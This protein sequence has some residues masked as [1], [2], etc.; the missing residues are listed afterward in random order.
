MEITKVRGLKRQ[1][2]GETDQRTKGSEAQVSHPRNE[3]GAK[4]QM[5]QVVTEGG[6]KHL[7]ADTL[8]KLNV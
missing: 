1:I 6:Y 3:K 8:E 5:I 7:E 4:W 2:S